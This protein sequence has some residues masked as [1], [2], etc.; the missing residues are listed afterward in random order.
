MKKTI[1]LFIILFSGINIHAQENIDL[2]TY[3]NTQDINFFSLIKN[4][5][6]VKEYL[7]VS[8]NSVKLGDTLTLGRPT[9]EE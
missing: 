9:S 2:L 1:T 3:E 6:Q 4:G 7:T 8:K 5:V